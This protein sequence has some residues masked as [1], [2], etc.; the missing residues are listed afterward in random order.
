MSKVVDAGEWTPGR[1]ITCVVVDIHWGFAVIRYAGLAGDDVVR[2]NRTPHLLTKFDLRLVGLKLA[3]PNQDRA[4]GDLQRV[5][6]LIL[7]IPMHKGAITESHRARARD[8][9]NLIAR[10]PKGAVHKAHAAG[11]GG[12]HPHH[13][14]VRAVEGDKLAVGDQQRHRGAVLHDHSR[15]TIIRA[16][17]QEIAVAEAARSLDELVADVVAKAER[18]KHVLPVAATED[19][20]LSVLLLPLE[21]AWFE[22]P[23]RVEMHVL[24]APDVEDHVHADAAPQRLAMHVPDQVPLIVP[25]IDAVVRV[26]Q[27]HRD[28][29]GILAAHRNRPGVRLRLLGR[30]LLGIEDHHTL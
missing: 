2:N 1:S 7:A 25:G 12:L 6:I 23:P 29:G 24:D 15:V 4:A 30:V 26:E 17:T 27:L 28:Y 21:K 10:A 14:R 22:A 11:V 16:D 18:V 3:A 13:R 9:R 20:R 5:A 19:K 8:L